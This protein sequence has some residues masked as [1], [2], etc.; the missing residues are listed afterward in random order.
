[1]SSPFRLFHGD[2]DHGDEI[3]TGANN[4]KI[5]AFFIIPLVCFVG[6]APT[7]FIKKVE[8]Y[9]LIIST[10]N[11][12][13]AGFILGFGFLHI[14]PDAAADWIEAGHN[15]KVQNYPVVYMLALVAFVLIL[16]IEKSV[17]E[18]AR[19]SHSHTASADLA[20]V[21]L[22]SSKQPSSNALD[23]DQSPSHTHDEHAFHSHEMFVN[24]KTPATAAMVT[25]GLSLHS[26]F[27]GIAIGLGKTE[28]STISVFIAILLHKIAEGFAIGINMQRAKVSRIQFFVLLSIF[29]AVVPIGVAIGWGVVSSVDDQAHATASAILNGFAVG[30]FMYI[31]I[32]G[33]MVE[34]FASGQRIYLKAALV[35]LAAAA[36]GCI[37]LLE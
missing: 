37:S 21:S 12:L 19:S 33:V 5:V 34:E 20:A 25:F 15:E 27:E 28:Y 32:L 26:V 8:S 23:T 18:Y 29:A 36:M 1:M 31:S 10:L 6:A 22:E 2:E 4:V 3:E 9:P 24:G 7:Y 30:V 16:V 11:C 14:L 35:I 17:L 13:A